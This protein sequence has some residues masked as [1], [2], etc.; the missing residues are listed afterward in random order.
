[1]SPSR[2]HLVPVRFRQAKDFMRAWHRHHAPLPGRSSP[3]APP[4]TPAP[5]APWRS[6]VGPSPVT[7]TSLAVRVTSKVVHGNDHIARFLWEAP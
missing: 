6:S 4:T 2:L 7:L 5:C 1:M 3:S